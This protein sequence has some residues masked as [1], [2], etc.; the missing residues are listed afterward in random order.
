[1]ADQIVVRSSSVSAFKACPTRFKLQYLDGLVSDKET[2]ATRMG[3]NW[4]ALQEVYRIAESVELGTGL[5]KACEHLDERYSEK[6]IH[7]ED[8][9]WEREKTVLVYSF[10]GYLWYWQNDVVE[11]LATEYGFTLPLHHPLTGLPLRTEEVV[12]NGTIDKIIR[13]NGLISVADYKST[14]RSIDADSQF[15]GHLRLDTQISMYIMALQELKAEGELAQFGVRSDEVVVG[16][17]YDV[18][19]KPTIRPKML[20]QKD[21][22]ALLETN[23]YLGESVTAEH[24]REWDEETKDE[25]GKTVVVHHH[26]VTLDGVDAVVKPGKK[27][28]A[29]QETAR[30]YGI[31]LLQDIQDRP[32]FYFARREI[33]RTQKDI[34]DFR[35]QLYNVYQ[36]MK[37]MRDNG[38]FFQNERQCEATFHCPYIPI[39]YAG[40]DISDGF[41]PEGM[42]RE[43]TTL[44][45]EGQETYD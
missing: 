7:V 6:P 34:T 10:I 27:G 3:T 16:A 29:V 15:W 30:M 14:S 25:K 20:T 45:I 17:F 23:T 42:K 41:T 2:E 8:A 24:V 18:W 36:S 37:T 13:R 35:A 33:P 12:R 9:D 32:A 31:R 21:T 26:H 44:T 22:A 43:I 5:D 1:M 4:H 39:C 40:V 19:H 38:H 28:F 11:T